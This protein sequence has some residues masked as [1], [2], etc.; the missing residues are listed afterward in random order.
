[1]SRLTEQQMKRYGELY[2]EL[3]YRQQYSS[4]EKFKETVDELK[5]LLTDP[6]N[7]HLFIAYDREW[8]HP[9]LCEFAHQHNNNYVTKNMFPKLKY[10]L[11]T[12]G[13]LL[14]KN[15]DTYGF[16]WYMRLNRWIPSSSRSIDF[17]EFTDEI[18]RLH[19]EYH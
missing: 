9:L 17:G 1:M 4:V 6:D 14:M 7:G 13:K 18:N 16:D 2:L 5:L 19:E 15:K 8:R 10:L 11:E 12:V 3:S